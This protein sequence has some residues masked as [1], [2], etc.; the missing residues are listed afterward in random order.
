MSPLAPREDILSRSERRLFPTPNFSAPCGEVQRKET[1]LRE[2]IK[3][4]MQ[5]LLT[6]KGL[7]AAAGLVREGE[8]RRADAGLNPSGGSRPPGNQ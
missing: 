5:K 2:A 6:T 8:Q 7:L 1:K 3:E 4:G